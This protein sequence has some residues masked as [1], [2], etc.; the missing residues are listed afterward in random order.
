M[1]TKKEARKNALKEMLANRFKGG[2]KDKFSNLKEK[3]KESK[4]NKKEEASE[5]PAFE[6]S[7]KD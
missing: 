5:T 3:M 7:E 2:K 1:A 4:E 6:K